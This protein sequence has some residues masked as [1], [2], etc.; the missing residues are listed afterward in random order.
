MDIATIHYLTA[1][2]INQ[3]AYYFILD[4]CFVNLKVIRIQIFTRNMKQY[5]DSD[6]QVEY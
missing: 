5:K 4:E 2:K 6:H 3:T 1:N